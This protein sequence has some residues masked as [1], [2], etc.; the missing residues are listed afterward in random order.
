MKKIFIF[1]TI[2]IVIIC[3]IAFQ[4]NSY[5]RNQNAIISENR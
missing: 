1:V 2:I 4:Y 5:K 3:I